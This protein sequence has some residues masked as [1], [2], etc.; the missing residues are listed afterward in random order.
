MSKLLFATVALFAA[1][2]GGKS[3]GETADPCKDPCKDKGVA[4]TCEGMAGNVATL[5]RSFG[6]MA[7]DVIVSMEA[8][9][10]S[11]CGSAGWSQESIDCYAA[12]TAEAD[13][14]TCEA[15]LTEEQ[16]SS[17][18]AAGAAAMGYSDEADMD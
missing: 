15:G 4:M 7:E 2:C 16:R 1:A 9:F 13:S 5:M 18:Q 8:A 6:E 12:M 14:E 3:G 17:L 10:T 11:E